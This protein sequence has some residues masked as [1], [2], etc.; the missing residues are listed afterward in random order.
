M[1]FGPPRTLLGSA[2]SLSDFIVF[3][4]ISLADF[5]LHTYLSLRLGKNHCALLSFKGYSLH[6]G[7]LTTLW[8][9]F[10][11]MMGAFAR[12]CWPQSCGYR[13]DGEGRR[14]CRRTVSFC[15]PA[16]RII[17]APVTHP[18]EPARISLFGRRNVTSRRSSQL[19]PT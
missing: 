17:G 5:R 2:R 11:R 16:N 15:V 14:G 9:S 6:D 12:A 13:I 1:A 4:I 8:G 18:R 7:L 10:S 19:L 3:V